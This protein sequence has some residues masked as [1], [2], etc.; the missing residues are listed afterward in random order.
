VPEVKKPKVVR[1]KIKA[2]PLDGEMLHGTAK[3]MLDVIRV[4]PKG[5]VAHVRSGICHVGI[6]YQCT[7]TLT[8]SRLPVHSDGQVWKTYDGVDPKT[9]G[10][11]RVVEVLF[12]KLADAERAKIRQFLSAIGQRE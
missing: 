6:H 8:V 1:K 11:L 12:V 7:L 5:F 9:R 2:Y 10:V 4:S 3:V